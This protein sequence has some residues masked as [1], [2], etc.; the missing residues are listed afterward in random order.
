[1]KTKFYVNKDART[2]VCVISGTRHFFQEWIWTHCNDIPKYFRHSIFPE[3]PN[4]FVGRAV[5][6][7]EDEWNED[8]GRLIAHS[9]ARNKLYTSFFKRAAAV[10]DKLDMTIEDM[11]QRVNQ[12]GQY[13]EDK[14]IG[15]EQRIAS[16]NKEE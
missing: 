3:M 14:R 9:R 11:V 10:T 6:A 5:C 15:T 16:F 12:Y 13:L 7:P 2:V 1:M 8:L 4:S